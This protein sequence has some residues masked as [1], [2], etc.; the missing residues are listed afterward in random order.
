M[1]TYKDLIETVIRRELGILGRGRMMAVLKDLN[2]VV[3]AEGRL[4]AARCDVADL[5]RLMQAL[6][7]RY[8]VVA[9][10]GCK[11]AVTRLARESGLPLPD[12]LK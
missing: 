8:G 2:M 4:G 6:S 5:D 3:D 7:E 10:M 9:V 1:A 12:I 11:I